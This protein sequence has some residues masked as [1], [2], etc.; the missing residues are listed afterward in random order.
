M[1]FVNG[2]HFNNVRGD[3]YGTPTVA[4]VALPLA[5]AMGLVASGATGMVMASMIFMKRM[6]DLQ[7]ESTTTINLPTEAFPLQDDE[8]AI[9]ENAKGQIILY[10][11]EGPLSF[12]AVKGGHNSGYPN[13]MTIKG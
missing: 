8:K 7:M 1:S 13:L 5:L 4:V 9:M 6:S 12:S 10:H 2:L 3:I 11:V